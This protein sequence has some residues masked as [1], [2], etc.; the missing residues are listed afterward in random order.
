MGL[1]KSFQIISNLCLLVILLLSSNTIYA[2]DALILC[3]GCNTTTKLNLMMSD[4]EQ[5]KHKSYLIKDLEKK[6]IQKYEILYE[7]EVQRGFPIAKR[8]PTEEEQKFAEEYNKWDR[9]KFL[10]GE[11]Y[12][13]GLNYHAY[14]LAALPILKSSLIEDYQNNSG[15]N[16]NLIQLMVSMLSNV[17]LALFSFNFKFTFPII[18]EDNSKAIVSFTH[19]EGARPQYEIIEL[20]D[21]D[22]NTIPSLNQKASTVMFTFNT[23]ENFNT[24]FLF[25]NEAYGLE[26]S[27]VT[28]EWIKKNV[29]TGTVII[30]DIDDDGEAEVVEPPEEDDPRDRDEPDEEEP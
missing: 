20:V 26:M 19:F 17:N 2:K 14:D 22:G 25:M 3:N 9:F 29:G 15:P 21:S 30:T 8:V 16:R 1:N 27:D 7:P 24:W 23:I 13:T 5:N 6:T 28:I 18:L 4:Y 11:S 10:L 12:R